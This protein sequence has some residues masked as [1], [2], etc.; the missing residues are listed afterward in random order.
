MIF[1]NFL[2]DV[3]KLSG[4]EV[5]M[6][7]EKDFLG[8]MEIGDNIYYGIHTK[9]AI[10]NFDV[11]YK[12]VNREVIQAMAKVK[13][14][15]AEANFRVEKLS[16][17]KKDAIKEA[18]E[19][20][21]SGKYDNQFLL[22][23]IQGGAGTSINMNINEVVA[24]IALEKLGN[25]KGEYDKLS[26]LEDVNMSQSTNDVYPT[27]VKIAVI[28][29]LR[30]LVDEIMELQYSLQDKE[31]EFAD[32]FKL[33]R[34]QLQDALPIS[35]GDEFGAY[36][37]VI[38]RD[39]WRLYKCEERIR[40]INLGGTAIG[41]GVGSSPKYRYIATEEIQRLTGFGLAR[42]ENLIDCTQNLDSFV[43]VSGFLKTLAVNLNKIGSDLRLMDSGSIGEINLP[44][45][46]AGSSIMPGKVNPV[47]AEFIKQIYYKV[48]GNDMALTVACGDGEFELNA[49]LP[50]I[51]DLILENLTL[52]RDGVRIFNSRV[53]KGVEA[54]REKC[55]EYLSK[56]SSTITL[57]IEKLG[58]DKLTEILNESKI[59]GKS[60]KEIIIEKGI[61]SGDEILEKY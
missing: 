51:A 61:L 33:G 52:L 25:K 45:L 12:K 26:P 48:L 19:E 31:S 37:E 28:K 41:T 5:I 6:R 40:Q 15:T 42:A 43:E 1:L 14:A 24:N 58:Y 50:V 59:S 16:L 20:V 56:S 44:K 4:E 32:V 29:I 36:A 3:F 21:Y 54:N 18:C 34:T 8:E 27:A 10:N 35:L 2:L 57:L 46:Q 55:M 30:E 13:M 39:R 47:G 23:A 49:M 17:E 11:E 53:I 22:P 60:Y 7:I 9:R 38:S